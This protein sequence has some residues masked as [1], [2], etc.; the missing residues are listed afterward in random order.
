MV[1]GTAWARR[2]S[3]PHPSVLQHQF[4]CVHVD[5]VDQPWLGSSW[6]VHHGTRKWSLQVAAAPAPEAQGSPGDP[7]APPGP[8]CVVLP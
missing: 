8:T 1:E 4:P 5:T 6:V 3:T 2:G 7:A